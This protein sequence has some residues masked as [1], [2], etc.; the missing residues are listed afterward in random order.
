MGKVWAPSR[1]MWTHFAFILLAA[2]SLFYL[3]QNCGRLGGANTKDIATRDRLKTGLFSPQPNIDLVQTEVARKMT[4]EQLAARAGIKLERE[5]HLDNF[6]V[7]MAHDGE[8]ILMLEKVGMYPQP[9]ASLD[10]AGKV[11]V[12]TF[13]VFANKET[14]AQGTAWVKVPSGMPPAVYVSE[15][16]NQ[17]NLYFMRHPTNASGRKTPAIINMLNHAITSNGM[18]LYKAGNVA[19]E[20]K[21]NMPVMT[22]IRVAEKIWRV[23]GVYSDRNIQNGTVFWTPD[24]KT[25]FSKTPGGSDVVEWRTQDDNS[26]D[27]VRRRGIRELEIPKA[28]ELAVAGGKEAIDSGIKRTSALGFDELAPGPR[29]IPVYQGRTTLPVN[30]RK[31]RL[32]LA[33]DGNPDDGFTDPTAQFTSDKAPALE[34]GGGQVE[35]SL[36]GSTLQLRNQN[37]GAWMN[38]RALKSDPIFI[39]RGTLNSF[40][41]GSNEYVGRDE[42]YEIL[43]AD[44]SP[45]GQYIRQ[46]WY[47]SMGLNSAYST[48]KHVSLNELDAELART[49]EGRD[50]RLRALHERNAEQQAQ[51]EAAL[52]AGAKAEKDFHKALQAAPAN[53]AIGTVK[54]TFKVNGL[55]NK[56]LADVAGEGTRQALAASTTAVLNYS[57]GDTGID[58]TSQLDASKIVTSGVNSLVKNGGLKDAGKELGFNF[59]AY[60]KSNLGDSVLSFQQAQVA[61]GA[62]L[63]SGVTKLSDGLVV[64]PL[65]S[66]ND[67][68]V[69][70][71]FFKTGVDTTKEIVVGL[72]PTPLSPG[73]ALVANV[74]AEEAKLLAV[75]GDALRSNVNAVNVVQQQAATLTRIANETVGKGQ[76]EIQDLRSQLADRRTELQQDS[77]SQGPASQQND[78]GYDEDQ[79]GDY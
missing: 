32:G 53:I 8:Q 1:L 74:A 35:Q 65:V 76:G 78:S 11:N 70:I 37:N 58:A 4:P 7:V 38:V 77:P 43:T 29:V 25:Y 45:T 34:L 47:P 51:S 40:F 72:L 55:G 79:S 27:V 50:E 6:S 48:Q 62:V 68:N 41:T 13:Q 31:F 52:A 73:A 26:I 33:E 49:Q 9:L 60:Q 36:P 21:T 57:L 75:G 59:T 44:G 3:T 15:D 24:F 19:F 5:H 67:P 12:W 54:D 46:Q 18:V 23:K 64:R 20:A 71:E 2:G 39:N 28:V 63:G 17:S 42:T 14:R 16:G 61:G 22:Y 30:Q 56:V 69:P 10:K 66:G